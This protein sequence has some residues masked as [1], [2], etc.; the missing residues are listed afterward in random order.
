MIIEIKD[1]PTDRKIKKVTFD[2][3]FEDGK[4]SSTTSVIVDDR[5]EL[6]PDLPTDINN[7]PAGVNPPVIDEKREKKEVPPEMTDMEF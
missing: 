3:E 6:F 7:I 5:D 1:F 2:V 4:P